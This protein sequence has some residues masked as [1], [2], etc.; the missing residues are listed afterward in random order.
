VKLRW[1]VSNNSNP[2][3]R[4]VEEA[5]LSPGSGSYAMDT[6]ARPETEPTGRRKEEPSRP[7]ELERLPCEPRG[8]MH[9]VAAG[10]G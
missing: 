8:S 4:S 9:W 2:T 7:T 5:L 3:C 10:S 6:E 1:D